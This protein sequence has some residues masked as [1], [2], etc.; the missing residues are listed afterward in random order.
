M[1]KKIKIWQEPILT[2]LCKSTHEENVLYTCKNGNNISGP[3]GYNCHSHN[4]IE[5]RGHHHR[6]YEMECS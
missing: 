6:C 1:I 2:I 4:T 3:N 5:N